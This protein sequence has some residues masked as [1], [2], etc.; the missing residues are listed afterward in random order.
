MINKILSIKKFYLL[1]IILFGIPSLLHIIN[2]G[3]IIRTGE[4]FNFFIRNTTSKIEPYLS[5]IIYA[6]FFIAMF[7]I[8]LIFL[9]KRKEIFKD[10]RSLFIFILISSILFAVIL[11]LT[12]SDVYSYATTGEIQSTYRANPYY[13]KIATVKEVNDTTN[14]EILNSIIIWD[15]QFVIYGPLWSLI[16][17]IVT[18]FSFSK[19]SIALIL[20]KIL[21][22]SIHCINAILIYKI[23]KKRFWVIFYGLNP[24]MMFET[25]SN[26]HN[27]IYLVFFTLLALYF[28]KNKKNLFLSLLFLAFATCIK[29]LTVLLF[30]ILLIYY[31]RKESIGQRIFKC[32]K[33]GLLFSG[34]V[35]AMYL[36]YLRNID[37]IFYVLIQQSKFRESIQA[38]LYILLAQFDL[39]SIHKYINKGIFI[40]CALLYLKFVL[41]LLFNIKGDCK[42]RTL[43]K[44]YNTIILIF[45][46]IFISNLCSWYFVWL[47]GTIMWQKK[48]NIK[49]AIYLPLIYEL[50]VSY[51]F[52]LKSDLAIKSYWFSIASIAIFY[53]LGC[54]RESFRLKH[55]E[56]KQLNAYK[57]CN[58]K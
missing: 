30:P 51:Y 56:T 13:D 17:S 35:I 22:I 28:F 57:K 7:V 44:N 36:L 8:Y 2:S 23:F 5:A 11:P 34:F 49:L 26:V 55:S 33:S 6:S 40:V 52:V 19:I 47:F 24:Y 1:L 10:N 58:I 46:L 43:I 4:Y 31:Y 37:M 29:Y 42:F 14:N 50:L 41:N 38:T 39:I 48:R 18:F 3:F 53:T 9:K 45:I 15:Q 12:S 27:D 16:C 32:I 54:L 20:F 25:I 21:A